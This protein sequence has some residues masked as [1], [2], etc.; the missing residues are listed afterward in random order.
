MMNN[1]VAIEYTETFEI[2]L[3]QLIG[4]L[5]DYSSE[6]VVI[7]K[8]EQLI[9]RF[10]KVVT[11]DPEAVSVS[12]SLLELG[13]VTFREFH[14]GIFRIIYRLHPTKEQTIVVD[15]IALQKQDLE[16]LLVQYCL[17]YRR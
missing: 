3:D 16:A 12:P 6:V 11:L 14:A 4:Y 8:I 10:E 7:E 15:L 2:L 1:R 17:L 13:I 5:A 9:E